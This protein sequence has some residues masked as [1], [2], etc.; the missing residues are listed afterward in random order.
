MTE[1]HVAGRPIFVGIGGDSGS[2]KTTLT[3]AFYSLF[4]EDRIATVCLDD[5]H[6]LDRRQRALVGLTPLNP[7]ANDFALMEEHLW[8]LKR[9]E[10][11]EK[12]VYD[13][14]DGT[15]GCP[16]R[17]EPRQVVIVQG[18]H[19]FLVPG[20]RNTFDLKVWLDPEA[21]LRVAWKLRRDV[22]R[23]GYSRE[24][25][26]A[27]IEARRFDAEAYIHPQRR[28]A[29][30]VVRFYRPTPGWEDMGHLSVRITQRHA[31]PRLSFDRSLHGAE[32]VHLFLDVLDEDGERSDVIEIE[33]QITT[34]EAGLLERTIWAHVDGVHG[35]VHHVPPER[36]G[37]YEAAREQRHS[38]PL[39]L[40]QLIL[41]H[42]ILSAQKSMMVRLTAPQHED[43]T[44][45]H[46][47]L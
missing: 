24:Q 13:H 19:P 6:S 25:V 16:R 9:G 39:A 17:L 37:T 40:T 31:L 46:R 35:S 7:R 30:M 11:I 12:P 42:R 2:G 44:W 38:D 28:W 18:L 22:A 34:H 3:A 10:A 20:I 33:G 32:R 26:L 43:L 41:A 4:G 8:A 29:D 27:E 23:R 1:M 5:Y 36:L 15:F 14:R 21:D 45:T 47:H